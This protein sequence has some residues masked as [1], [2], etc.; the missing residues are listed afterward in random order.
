[1]IKPRKQQA[2]GDDD[3]DIDAACQGTVRGEG[4]AK[5]DKNHRG[6]SCFHLTRTVRSGSQRHPDCVRQRP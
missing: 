1:M 6:K 4:K 3:D 2:K 5:D